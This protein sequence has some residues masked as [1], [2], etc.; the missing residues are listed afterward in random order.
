MLVPVRIRSLFYSIGCFAI[1][2][3]APLAVLFVVP[4]GFSVHGIASDLW[5]VSILG[6]W[7]LAAWFLIRAIFG[8]S[9]PSFSRPRISA[10]RLRVISRSFGGFAFKALLR[11]MLLAMAAGTVWLAVNH[12]AISSF[13]LACFLALATRT[14]RSTQAMRSDTT[15]WFI[16][17]AATGYAVHELLE[18]RTGHGGSGPLS[19]RDSDDQSDHS[20]ERK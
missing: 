19:L 4:D 17:G 18:G 8:L 15:T 5:V 10:A 9:K 12:W 2:I 11:G 6:L 1:S 13:L 14:G 16:V 7:A 20:D 3:L